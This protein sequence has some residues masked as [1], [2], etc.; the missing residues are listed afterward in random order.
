MIFSYQVYVEVNGEPEPVGEVIERR[1]ANGETMWKGR[2]FVTNNAGCLFFDKKK[3]EDY[4][5]NLAKNWNL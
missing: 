5:I 1:T 2:S 3:T 4:L